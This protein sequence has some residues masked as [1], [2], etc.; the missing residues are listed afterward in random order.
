[1]EHRVRPYPLLTSC[2]ATQQQKQGSAE[3]GITS[4]SATPRAPPV[5]VPRCFD[6]SHLP[7][8]ERT[9]LQSGIFRAVRIQQNT[10]PRT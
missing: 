10:T 2:S 9:T 7:S 4:S 3:A 5:G 8:S 1:M 6:L